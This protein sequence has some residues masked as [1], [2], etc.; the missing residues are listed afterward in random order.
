MKE[1]G[2]FSCRGPVRFPYIPG[3]LSF[4]ELPALLK[5]WKRIKKRPDL[6]FVDGQGIAHPR[7][8]GIASHLGVLLGQATIG[9]AKSRLVGEYE[10]PARRKGSCSPLKY[11]GKKVGEVLR[12]RT[13]VKPVFIS[14]GHLINVEDALRW[15]LKV[16]GRYRIPEPTRQADIYVKQLRAKSLVLSA[17][18]SSKH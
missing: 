10:M 2:R 5:L 11:R 3:L 16:T 9:V 6:V 4:R 17:A 15:A 14:P 12:T 18:L 13:A 7:R 1:V 8:I